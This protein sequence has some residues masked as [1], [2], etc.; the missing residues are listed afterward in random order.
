MIE[1]SATIRY[2][3]PDGSEGAVIVGGDTRDDLREAMDRDVAYYVG[4]GYQIVGAQV[5]E[6]CAECH[7][8][9]ERPHRR[10]RLRRVRCPSCRGTGIPRI[11]GPSLK[12]GV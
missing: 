12:S 6:V 10:Q 4:I 3:R 7:G 8:D 2:R 1:R 9:G 5:H 11:P